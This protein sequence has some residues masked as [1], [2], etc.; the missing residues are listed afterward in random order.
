MQRRYTPLRSDDA[1][2]IYA[3]VESGD[4]MRIDEQFHAARGKAMSTLC[5]WLRSVA[6]HAAGAPVIIVGSSKDVVS[7]P[8]QHR[9][10]VSRTTFGVAFDIMGSRRL[11]LQSYAPGPVGSERETLLLF[12]MDNT[13]SGSGQTDAVV[14]RACVVPS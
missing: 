11:N 12:P 9:R 7:S 14:E 2:D 13:Q 6:L 8:E 4:E 10:E 1:T 3:A 5:F